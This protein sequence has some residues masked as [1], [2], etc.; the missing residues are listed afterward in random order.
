VTRCNPYGAETAAGHANPYG[1]LTPAVVQETWYCPLPGEVRVR[2]R[3]ANG[4]LG[5]VFTVC[6]AHYAEFQGQRDARINGM[7]VPIPWN[8][9]RNVQVCPRCASQAPDCRN[10]DH[11]SMTRGRSGA[12]GR[13]GCQETKVAVRL[14]AVS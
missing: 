14:V 3:C 10:P 12:P 6:P 9:R 8:L 7:R 4:H 13:C 1:G 2:W 11:L 5:E